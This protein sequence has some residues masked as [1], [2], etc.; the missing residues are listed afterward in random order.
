MKMPHWEPQSI[1]RWRINPAIF[2]VLLSALPQSLFSRAPNWVHDVSSAL[3][4][5]LALCQNHLKRQPHDSRVPLRWVKRS[6][7]R[8]YFRRVH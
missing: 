8:H 1:P 2:I 3:S 7:P 4:K 6:R 5:A